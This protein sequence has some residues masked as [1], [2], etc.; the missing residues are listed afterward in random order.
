MVRLLLAEVGRKLD[1]EQNDS[2]RISLLA[3]IKM[4]LSETPVEMGNKT[5]DA[6]SIDEKEAMMLETGYEPREIAQERKG[7]QRAAL[8]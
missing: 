4:T 1:R 7:L 5:G 8:S 6:N 3:S 2:S